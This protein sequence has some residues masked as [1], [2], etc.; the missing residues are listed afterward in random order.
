MAAV[1]VG[2]CAESNLCQ[3]GEERRM[4]KLIPGAGQS[5]EPG[6]QAAPAENLEC[7]PA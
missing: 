4:G 3:G 6:K 5:M 7:V 2:A 1:A